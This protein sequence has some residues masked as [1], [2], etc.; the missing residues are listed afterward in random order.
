MMPESSFDIDWFAQD[1]QGN[2]M[3]FASGGGKLPFLVK[4]I[5]N[6]SLRSFFHEL[7]VKSINVDYSVSLSQFVWLSG[8]ELE[9]YLQDFRQMTQKGLYSFD[10][11][12]LSNPSDNKYHLVCKPQN[13]IS[14]DEIPV[15]VR[16]QLVKF[17]FAIEELGQQV[18][19][20]D[21]V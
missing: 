21:Y 9:T 5:N 7:P 6:N 10:K 15:Q 20:S 16:S 12:N 1:M 14:I 13:K 2:I 8:H 4:Q 11:S 17:N 19:I 3:H 18:D